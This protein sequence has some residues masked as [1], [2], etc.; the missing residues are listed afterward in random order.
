[1]AKLIYKE[2]FLSIALLFFFFKVSAQMSITGLQCVLAQV[3]YQYQ[4]K[5]EWREGDQI[6]ICVQ[7]GILSENGDS[8]II[9]TD[10]TTVKIK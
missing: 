4:L 7:G 3:E 2:T 8:C 1:M 10:V 6:S 9:K 5:L